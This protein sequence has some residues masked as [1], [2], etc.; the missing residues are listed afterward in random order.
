MTPVNYALNRLQNGLSRG[1]FER[2]PPNLGG[3]G[4]FGRPAR[5]L[6]RRRNPI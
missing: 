4:R 3:V 6:T 5:V 2:Y 1:F